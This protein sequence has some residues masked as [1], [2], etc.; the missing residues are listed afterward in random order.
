MS[1]KR[2]THGSGLLSRYMSRRAIANLPVRFV[3]RETDPVL[4]DLPILKHLR[5]RLAVPRRQ[6][7]SV[8]CVVLYAGEGVHY[9]VEQLLVL[10]R[11]LGRRVE[12]CGQRRTVGGLP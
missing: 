12:A 2:N 6:A 8:L 7:V 10:L 5:L 1:S 9:C 3:I 4:P 11:E